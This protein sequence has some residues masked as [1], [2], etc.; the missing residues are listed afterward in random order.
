LE[1]EAEAWIRAHVPGAV[2]E[3]VH[4]RPWATAARVVL[5][6]RMA[7]FKACAPIQAFEVRLTAVLADRWPELL[8]GVVAWD[9]VR[10]WLLLADAG[11]AVGFG[12]DPMPWIS[13]F[14]R[15]AELQRRE[16]AHAAEHL[17]DGVPDRRLAAFPALY[18]AFLEHELPISGDERARLQRFAPRFAALCAELAD[19][20]ISE[21]IQHDDLHG[22][23]VFLHD[24][25]PRILDW[26]DS[27]VSHPFLSP[28]VTFVHIEDGL[29][30]DD[31]R[32]GR[33]RDAY[34]EPWGPPAELRETFDLAQRLGPF[35]HMFKEI[36]VLDA[37]ADG[38][39][40]VFEREFVPGFAPVLAACVAAAW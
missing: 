26:G 17:A 7:W 6:D 22:A 9:D 8:P 12:G 33:L 16:T 24:G 14:P 27:C 19:H 15:Y 32:Y 29:D 25:V 34:L 31:A 13:L 11:E 18:D 37:I 1:S 23:N 28:F 36:R 38:D 40:A 20:G 4:E 30:A 10:A 21:T 3:V 39:R 5:A 2:I 35:A